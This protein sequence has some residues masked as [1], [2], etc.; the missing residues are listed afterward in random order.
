MEPGLLVT[1]YGVAS[2]WDE[3]IASSHAK[4]TRLSLFSCHCHVYPTQ[5]RSLVNKWTE[6]ACLLFACAHM[7]SGLIRPIVP[8]ILQ[9]AHLRLR[10]SVQAKTGLV[11]LVF[12]EIEQRRIN[13]YCIL[14]S[15]DVRAKEHGDVLIVRLSCADLELLLRPIDRV[16][17]VKVKAY[18]FTFFSGTLK[19]RRDIICRN[20]RCLLS[21]SCRSF[22]GKFFTAVAWEA[23]RDRLPFLRLV[24]SLRE[25]FVIS[26]FLL[27]K[28]VLQLHLIV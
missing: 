7:W 22:V 21:F 18:L 1:V 9:E 8:P 25:I 10:L 23:R 13:D 26:V 11:L 15:L 5:F 6:L 17:V 16:I 3:P 28:V 14:F 19:D 12:R 24:V 27:S 20:F 2:P 4:A